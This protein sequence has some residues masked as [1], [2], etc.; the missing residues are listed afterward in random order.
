MPPLKN[1]KHEAFCLTYVNDP[2]VRFNATQ[3]YATVYPNASYDTC[4]VNG[5]RLLRKTRD[6]IQELLEPY[7]TDTHLKP[8]ID[9]LMGAL[10]SENPRVKMAAVKTCL[11]LYGF[12]A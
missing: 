12:K 8:V 4:S 9:T 5:C 7:S 6:R 11:R 10:D 1:P 2:E 3:S